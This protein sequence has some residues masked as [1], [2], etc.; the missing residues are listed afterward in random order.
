MSASVNPPPELTR[1]IFGGMLY[2]FLASIVDAKNG[3]P[4][5][6]QPRGNELVTDEL[7]TQ[8]P[9]PAHRHDEGPSL[10]DLAGKALL[11]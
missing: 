1:C 3:M 7:D 5:T 11:G 10:V 2:A 6:L 8:A 4:T 9:G